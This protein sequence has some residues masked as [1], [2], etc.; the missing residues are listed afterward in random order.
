MNILVTVDSNYVRPLKVML[1][2][3]FTYHKNENQ[4]YLLYSNVKETELAELRNMIE[5]RGSRFFPVRMEENLLSNVPVF[6]Y[7]T[8]EMYYR[9]FAGVMFLGKDK[10]LYLDPDILIRGSLEELYETDIE[11][12]VLAGVADYAI[13]HMTEL[14]MHKEELGMEEREQYI[15][16]GVLVLNLKELR[17]RFRGKDIERIV[18]EKGD[19]LLYPDQD[20]INLLFRGRIKVLERKYNYNTGYGS[21]GKMLKYIAGGFIKEKQYPV[22]VHYMGA[23]KPWHPEYYGKFGKEYRSYLKLFPSQNADEE[24]KWKRRKTAIAKHL[25]KIVIRKMGGKNH[26]K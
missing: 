21:F 13:N 20:I 12:N 2:S 17:K 15:N 7:F 8:K 22:I 14:S 11:E 3:F 16:S 6:R 25:L 18:K 1:T 10:M 19:L 4:I 9:L 5:E 24:R 26:G 23:S